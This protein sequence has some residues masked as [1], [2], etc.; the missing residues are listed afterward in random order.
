MRKRFAARRGQWLGG[1]DA[2]PM[3]IALG[4]PSENDAACQIDHL[5]AWIDAWRQHLHSGTLE[6]RERRWRDL[7]TQ[8]LPA[9]LVLAA[10]DEVAAWLGETDRW[11]SARERFQRLCRTWPALYDL[12][13]RHYNMLADYPDADF[14]RL[15]SLLDGL[16]AHP[17]SFLY[18]RQLPI[19]GL[20]SKWLEQRRGLVTELAAALHGVDP[21]GKD[22]YAV[23]GLRPMPDM[24][25]MRLLDPA[26]RQRLGGLG[27]I[28]APVEQLA[29]L[30]LPLRWVFIVENLQ[31]GL[32]FE[33]LPDTVVIMGLGYGIDRI[34]RFQWLE[35]SRCYYWGDID[36]HGFAILHRARSHLPQLASLLMDQQTLLAHKSLWVEEKQPH[37][38]DRLPR[39]TDDEQALY[40]GLKENR[41]GFKVRLE[42]ERIAWPRAWEC[43]R[44]CIGLAQN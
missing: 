44:R 14:E 38:A 41:W 42:Q 28:S 24:V 34:A 31:T 8:R 6:W 29:E 39:L 15:V 1:G 33:D 16:S 9:R 43:I 5:R 2:W 22:L 10:P 36:T 21:K 32:A 17:R 26:L 23:C 18:P 25:R 37:G 19:A 27:D 7:G 13:P 11:R 40:R 4:N 3:V 12:L 30:A 35:R 20:D